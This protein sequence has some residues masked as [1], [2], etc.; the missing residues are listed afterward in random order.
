MDE[1]VVLLIIALVII[2]ALVAIG[3][4]LADWAS[5]NFTTGVGPTGNFK[6]LS[7]FDLGNVGLTG[8]QAARS[9]KFGSFTLGQTQS[10]TLRE[11]ASV[12]VSQGYF[13]SD[14]KKFEITVDPGV[15]GSLRSAKISFDMG[16]T[17][18]YGN[19]IIKWND[20]AVFDRLANLNRFEI[21][22]PAEDVKESNVLEM[23][24]A[25]PGLYFWSATY[26]GLQNF[27]VAA[28]YGPEKIMS[29]KV[30]PNELEAWD[31]GILKFYTTSGQRGDIQVKLNGQGIYSSS[32]PE[33]LVTKEFEFSQIGNV[34]R[35]GD[36]IISFRSSSVFE[37][38][39]VSFDI[40][41]M[42]GGSVKERYFNLTRADINLLKGSGRGR[43]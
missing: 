8:A 31:R 12:G 16:E 33:H 28:E 42:G 39:D 5:G 35:A 30:Y 1:F 26:Y 2:G 14:P 19:L 13:G 22:I 40:Y 29:F 3:T 25:P 32:N 6:L 15:L 18:L 24:A 7:S 38:D 27:R 4:P 10:E 37:L 43:R 41:L 34:I 23:S 20:K 21:T 9:V 36:N 11:M 17:N